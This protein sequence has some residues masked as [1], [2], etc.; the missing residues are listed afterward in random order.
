M[1]NI[2]LYLVAVTSDVGVGGTR[3]LNAVVV[4]PPA[5]LQVG[6]VEDQQTLTCVDIEFVLYDAATDGVEGLVDIQ[7]RGEHIREPE[8]A[9]AQIEHCIEDICAYTVDSQE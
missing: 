4:A 6:G 9:L 8:L 5:F 3:A 2:R 7:V 1:P